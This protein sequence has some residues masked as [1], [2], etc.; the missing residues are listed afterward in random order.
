MTVHSLFA[1]SLR[2]FGYI[3]TVSE[4]MRKADGVRSVLLYFLC[5][6]LKRLS[7]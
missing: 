7:W 6:Y 3:V 4:K 5:I 2:K 1:K